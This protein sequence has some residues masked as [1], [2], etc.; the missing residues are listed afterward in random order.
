MVIGVDQVGLVPIDAVV[1]DEGLLLDD[2]SII[3]VR[4]IIGTCCELSSADL[5]FVIL[6]A[7]LPLFISNDLFW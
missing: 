6:G 7:L 2:P 5:D 4:C 3:W 1:V